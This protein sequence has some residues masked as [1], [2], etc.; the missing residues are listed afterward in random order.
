MVMQ[1]GLC[2]IFFAYLAG[3]WLDHVKRVVVTPN[4]GN[5]ISYKGDTVGILKPTVTKMVRKR[6]GSNYLSPQMSEVEA[7][8]VLY[9]VGWQ[10]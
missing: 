2:R 9:Q 4:V 3:E 5:S 6:Y 10:G 7:L 8:V 1:R